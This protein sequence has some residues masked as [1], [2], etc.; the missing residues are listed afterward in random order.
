[1]SI[2]IILADDHKIILDGLGS[3]LEKETGM[4]VIAEADDG[5]KTVELARKLSP[6]VII[7]DI[8]MP[9]MNGVEATRQ[10]VADAPKVKV[11]GLSMHSDRSFVGEM[12]KAGASGYL[13]KKSAFEELVVAIRTVVA[14]KTYLSPEITGIIVEE[15]VSHSSKSDQSPS[16]VLTSKER[17]V[18]QLLSEGK[19]AKEIALILHTSVSTMETHR[20]HIMKKLDINSIPQLTKYA[21]REGLTSLES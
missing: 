21:I 3:L 20:S 17:E 15:Y 7:M 8:G 5:R 11:I 4:E 14:N 16:S 10:I 18:L 1:M 19:T 9:N 12:L 6:D 2:R 13:L